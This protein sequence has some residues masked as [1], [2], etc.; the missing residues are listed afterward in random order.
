M[1][2]A[3]LSA[4]PRP[5][6][7]QIDAGKIA[8]PRHHHDHE[9]ADGVGQPAIGVDGVGHRGERAGRAADRGVER[10]GQ[11]VDPSRLDAEHLR[12]RAGSCAVARIAWPWRERARNSASA[13]PSAMQAANTISLILATPTSPSKK[14]QLPSPL[15]AM[16]SAPPKAAR[17][18]LLHDDG[19]AE[20]RQHRVEHV[21]AHEMH[22]HGPEQDPAER[23]ERQRPRAARQA[24]AARPARRTAP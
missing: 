5:K 11:A 2:P 16:R 9:R 10:I 24:A 23:I 14:N 21:A 8:E 1:K 4:T 18:Q 6:A 19:D 3:K 15:S 13:S 20:G 22:D 17:H 7:A 12:R